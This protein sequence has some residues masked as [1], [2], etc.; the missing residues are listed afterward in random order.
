MTK[1]QLE[2]RKAPALKQ[3]ALGTGRLL[4]FQQ[5]K[6]FFLAH[7]AMRHFA[8]WVCLHWAHGNP[9]AV[10]HRDCRAGRRGMATVTHDVFL[11]CLQRESSNAELPGSGLMPKIPRQ[12]W[13][14]EVHPGNQIERHQEKQGIVS[15]QPTPQVE[16]VR[17]GTLLRQRLVRPYQ[18]VC[19]GNLD[20]GWGTRLWHEEPPW[21]ISF[22][23]ERTNSSDIHRVKTFKTQH[24][25]SSYKS[26][27]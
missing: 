21:F 15:L 6:I 8:R 26:W 25:L 13:P 22:L 18:L 3:Q 24:K 4:L 9:M 14:S 11:I 5:K 23:P 20:K 2:R 17:R 27:N 10:C 16:R 19:T 12:W 1:G 7:K